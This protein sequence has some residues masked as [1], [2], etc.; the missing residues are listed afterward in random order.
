MKY[1]IRSVKYF[2]YFAFL[3]TAII[4]ALIAIGAV[5][6]NI[7]TIFEDGYKTLWKIAIFFALVAA[8]YPNLAF[9]TRQVDTDATRDS[10][11]EEITEFMK[12]RRYELESDTSEGMTF[13]VRSLAGKLSKMYEDRV[14]FRWN[15][16]GFTME[17]LRKDLLRLAAGLET[18][19]LRN[20]QPE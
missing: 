12:E 15:T 5:E 17:G 20:G 4:F 16:E 3:T 19:F 18:R 11:K 7:D 6:G 9:I 8:V 1:F 14:T 13:R 10:V 2:F